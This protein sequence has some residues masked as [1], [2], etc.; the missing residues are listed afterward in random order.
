MMSF[1]SLRL[2]YG[3][4][5]KDE[6]QWS[7][8][9]CVLSQKEVEA[10]LLCLINLESRFPQQAKTEEV[11]LHQVCLARNSSQ[12]VGSDKW[13][14]NPFTFWCIDVFKGQW[15]LLLQSTEVDDGK[16]YVNFC[17]IAGTRF[18]W[19]ETCQNST[20]HNCNFLWNA[21][22]VSSWVIRVFISGSCF[23]LLKLH[24]SSKSGYQMGQFL[25]KILM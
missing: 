18:L 5:S 19:K 9:T 25:N 2:A 11:Y 15:K 1:Q 20:L 23:H 8:W 6:W 16:L 3:K 21:L 10:S 13:V 7:V 4:S 22:T 12:V 17:F 14:S 24:S